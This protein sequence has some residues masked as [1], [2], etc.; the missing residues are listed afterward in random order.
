MLELALALA[1]RLLDLLA[2]VFKW[3]TLEVRVARRTTAAA[4]RVG[5]NLNQKRL[6]IVLSGPG[7]KDRFFSPDPTIRSGTNVELAE[8]LS[9]P[10]GDLREI[11]ALRPLLERAYLASSDSGEALRQ[12]DS[13][14]QQRADRLEASFSR[15]SRDIYLF[16]SRLAT[17]HPLR[18]REFRDLAV[19]WDR[20]PAMLG[21]LVADGPDQLSY[22]AR[23]PATI[24]GDAPPS[25]FGVAANVASDRG[26]NLVAAQLIDRGLERGLKLPEYWSVRLLQLREVADRTAGELLLADYRGHPLVEASLAPDGRPAARKLLEEWRPDSHAEELHRRVLLSELMLADLLLD[27]AIV[28]ALETAREFSSTSSR[29][30]AARALLTRSS[31]GSSVLRR[32]DESDALTQA[33]AARADRIRWGLPSGDAMALVLKLM[34]VLNDGQGA[35][36]F[37]SPAPDGSA[38]TEEM[39]TPGVLLEIALLQARLGRI[40][41]AKSTIERMPAGA[42]K[43]RASAALAE[44]VSDS[45]IEWEQAFEST[46]DWGTKAEIALQ[47]AL[48]GKRIDLGEMG[49]ANPDIAAELLAIAELFSKEL[50]A[51]ERFR[52]L[53][54]ASARCTLLLLR[55]FQQEEDAVNG[56][57]VA[58]AGA[59]AWND[60]DLWVESAQYRFN[61]GDVAGAVEELHSALVSSPPFWGG[62]RDTYRRLVEAYSMLGQ[63]E[64]ARNAAAQLLAQGDDADS[65]WALVVCQIRTNDPFGALHTWQTHER[66]EPRTEMQTG[67]WIELFRVHGAAFANPSDAL[68]I[69]AKWPE[70]EPLRRA[71]VGALFTGNPSREVSGSVSERS[72][73]PEDPGLEEASEPLSQEQLDAAAL[74]QDY[75]RDFPEGGIWQVKFDPDDP[76][77]S[78]KRAIGEP[79]DTRDADRQVLVG[80]LPSGFS[81]EIHRRH[82]LEVLV[83]KPDGPLHTGARDAAWERAAIAAARTGQVIVDTSTLYTRAHLPND[84]ASRLFGGFPAV[85]VVTEQHR[86]AVETLSGFRRDSGMSVAA[87]PGG[88]DPR[89]I[90]APGAEVARRL[91]VA[92]AAVAGFAAATS[93]SHPSIRAL[94]EIAGQPFHSP[95]MAAVDLALSLSVPLWVDDGILRSM[96]QSAGGTAFGTFELLAVLSEE[97]ALDDEL[98]QLVEGRLIAAGY[99]GTAFD[100]TVW[101]LAASIGQAGAGLVNAIAFANGDDVDRRA[102]FALEYIDTSAADPERLVASVYAAARWIVAIA[103]DPNA[104]ISNLEILARSLL[105]RAWMN[106]STLPFCVSGFTG[107]I[108]IDQPASV[109]LRLVFEAFAALKDQVGHEL[110][111][112]AIFELVSKLNEDDGRRVRNSILV[113]HF[114]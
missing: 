104:A 52:E 11:D 91:Q 80:G 106:S 88:A 81:A 23:Y 21:M 51:L 103:G 39:A 62:R 2:R 9:A 36:R 7:F 42:S 67:A 56:A 82:Y 70:N 13:L 47:L 65:V 5:L 102:K 6:R 112:H 55:Y 66:P 98:R 41:L 44:R 53:A 97:G 95:V 107:V 20:A 93:I 86:D 58:R 34:Q 28:L 105:G 113:G 74:L 19:E 63:W 72:A 1:D 59:K 110:A 4:R 27:D 100:E 16:E 35:L 48:L 83:L 96:V 114:E 46:D 31:V 43:S 18:A 54:A 111:A 75:L 57:L 94:S 38:T 3:L 84:L 79:A 78:L 99:A 68:A 17:L 26:L 85:R 37:A 25:F 90:N 32:Y 109:M 64:D 77:G 33:L 61:E 14:D 40:D 50:G 15:N 22:W 60:Y 8:A 92:E 76:L 73:D 24:F 29:L 69:A 87:Q 89:I 71:L 101:Q 108:D 49:E 12:K 30:I 45:T 10:T